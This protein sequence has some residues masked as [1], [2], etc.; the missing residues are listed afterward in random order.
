[1]E[2]IQN[3]TIIGTSLLIE[4]GC[5]TAWLYVEFD[6]G[7]QGFGGH[8]LYTEKGWKTGEANFAGRFIFEILRITKCQEWEK[9]KGY[10]IRVKGTQ[11][12]LTGIGHIIEDRWFN[13]DEAFTNKGLVESSS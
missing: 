10:N 12:K 7:G 5:L 6:G 9:L 8:A 2:K 3:A 4:R 13:L 1:M 11:S